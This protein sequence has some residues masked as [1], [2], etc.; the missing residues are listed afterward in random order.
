MNH[1]EGKQV[2]LSRECSKLRVK[3]L[4]LPTWIK[5]HLLT[6][7]KKCFPSLPKVMHWLLG[8]AVAEKVPD[9]KVAEVQVEWSDSGERGK[10]GVN[11]IKDSWEGLRDLIRVRVNAVLGKYKV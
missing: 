8:Y 6:S 11:P 3:L 2:L 5:R 4:F 1:I 10:H 9:Y 7:L